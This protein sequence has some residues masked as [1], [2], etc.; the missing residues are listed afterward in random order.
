MIKFREIILSDKTLCDEYFK[1]TSTASCDYTFAN[2]YN[3]REEFNYR[4]AFADGF[5]FVRFG[6][7]KFKYFLPIGKG[8]IISALNLLKEENNE[9]FIYGVTQEEIECLKRAGVPV[10]SSELYRD[11]SD[12][13]Y[14]CDDLKTLAGKRFHSKRNF[15]SR[16]KSSYNWSY[17]PIDKTN[18]KECVD[19]CF[20]WF[21][22][23]ETSDAKEEE[24]TVI[25]A[26]N[27]FEQLGLQG[28]LIRVN[29]KVVAFTVGEP[30]NNETF[31]V[32]IEKADTRYVGVYAMLNNQFVVNNCSTYKY[33]N[34]EEDMGIEGLRKAKESYYPAFILNKYNITI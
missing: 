18:I 29:G 31:C 23:Q 17:E 2:L 30:I 20:E 4:I 10:K 11:A 1:K 26:L 33:I 13:I 21:D 32:H 3:W 15:I 25:S 7:D 34:R 22:S 27:N 9:L 6:K 24:K 8:N 16:F 12:Y 14:L 5:M 28:G 19:F